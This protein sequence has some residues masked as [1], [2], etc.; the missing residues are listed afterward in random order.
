MKQVRLCHQRRSEGVTGDESSES[1]LKD[2]LTQ[3]IRRE[4]EVE[5]LG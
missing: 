4:S 2:D 5:R 3:A 1:T